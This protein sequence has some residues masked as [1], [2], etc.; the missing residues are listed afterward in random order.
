MS[1]NL[2]TPE[3]RKVAGQYP[4]GP[5]IRA[6]AAGSLVSYEGFLNELDMVASE[7][8]FEAF[9]DVRALRGWAESTEDP[10]WTD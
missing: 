6:F 4:V 10:V 9:D 3:A 2:T 7:Y 1:D 8:S 5:R